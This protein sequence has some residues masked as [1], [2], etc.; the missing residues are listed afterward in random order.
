MLTVIRGHVSPETAY[1]VSDYPYGRQLR[2][3]IRYWLET[4]KSH[5]MRFVSQTT[6]PKKNNEVFSNKA[7]GSIYNTFMVMVVDERGYVFYRSLSLYARPED[8]ARFEAEG[9][10]AQLDEQ[11][12]K[13]HD[14]L[15]AM[16]RKM[17]PNSWQEWD[18]VFVHAEHMAASMVERD[19]AKLH[20]LYEQQHGPVYLPKFQAALEQINAR[21][22]RILDVPST[23]RGL[24]E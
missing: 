16:S 10:V 17:N 19:V 23:T 21:K 22:G 1:I 15:L 13:T 8:F 3:K 4:K 6:N 5:G 2:C 12:R 9:V 20:A 7:K 11:E 14:A 18:E 24:E